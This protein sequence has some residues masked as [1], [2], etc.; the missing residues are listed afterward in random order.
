MSAEFS[1]GELAK[2]V[3][4]RVRGDDDLLVRGIATLSEAGPDELSFLTNPRYRKQAVTSRAGAVLVAPGTDLPGRHL[5]EAAQPYYALAELL[6]LFNP[7]APRR[8]GIAPSAVVADAVS[9]G[10][11]AV[12][13]H[14]AVVEDG[15]VLGK[16]VTVAAGC[17]VGVDCRIGDDT[18]LRPR[19]VLY[20]GT[21]IGKRC[22]IHAGVVLGSD[23]FGFA[24]TD[25]GH[26]KVSQLGRVVIEDDVEIGANCTVDRGTLGETRIGAGTKI[27]NL[28][29]VA[30]GVTLGPGCLLAAQA[31]IAGSTRIG[32]RAILAGQAGVSGH[33]EI[34][35]GVVVA[36]KSAVFD[37]VTRGSYVAG[38]PAIDQRRWNRAQAIFRRLPDLR[39][40]LRALSDRVRE[41][42]GRIDD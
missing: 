40:E 14:C 8:P 5:L 38:V 1:L 4:G 23:G 37:D 18:E 35:D 33:L 27:D 12:I 32:A 42:E 21:R 34:G 29:M 15:A 13:G 22:L 39:R 10:S 28:V 41:L 7:P 6:D 20:P 11:E 26:R 17:V 3:G 24:T 36:G 2:R 9:V 16:R 19:V 25:A 30:H 31:G